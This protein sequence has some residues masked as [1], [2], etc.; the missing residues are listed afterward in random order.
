M[1]KTK[2]EISQNTSCVALQ[3]HAA[4]TEV[5]CFPYEFHPLAWSPKSKYAVPLLYAMVNHKLAPQY[6]QSPQLT[7]DRR[8]TSFGNIVCIVL[9]GQEG[10]MRRTQDID[11]NKKGWL[12]FRSWVTKAAYTSVA[13]KPMSTYTM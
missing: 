9:A 10:A 3:K 2:V 6:S 1:N 11:L 5:L 8:T 4:V 7:Y 12:L 13:S